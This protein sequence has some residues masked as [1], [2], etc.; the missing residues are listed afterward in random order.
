MGYE[1]PIQML[2]REFLEEAGF[3]VNTADSAAEAMMKPALVSGGFDAVIADVILPVPQ[4]QSMG[5]HHS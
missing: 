3:K 1:P 2:G 4:L 5:R